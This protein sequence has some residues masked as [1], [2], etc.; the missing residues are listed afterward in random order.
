MMGQRSIR[1]AL[2]SVPS[3]LRRFALLLLLTLG[4]IWAVEWVAFRRGSFWHLRDVIS[5]MHPR[6][7]NLMAAGARHVDLASRPPD[8]PRLLVVGS[9][10]AGATFDPAAFDTAWSAEAS[11]SPL[12]ADL[13]WLGGSTLAD[14]IVLTQYVGAPPPAYAVLAFAR[15]DVMLSVTKEYALGVRAFH[16]PAMLPLDAGAA[17]PPWSGSQRLW[18]LAW[19]GYRHRVLAQQM[20][21]RYR[22]GMRGP[23]PEA[24]GLWGAGDVEDRVRFVVDQPSTAPRGGE[25]V[26]IP[27][28]VAWCRE[29]GTQPVLWAL[30]VRP[31]RLQRDLAADVGRT[32]LE[33]MAALAEA[34][35]A[36]LID[37]SGAGRVGDYSETDDVHPFPQAAV[38]VTRQFADALAERHTA[39]RHTP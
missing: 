33:R 23:D 6:W 12:G 39:E 18:R 34:H 29:R 36:W 15:R 30:P 37:L 25:L 7:H 4:M 31:D 8:R 2:D 1:P 11:R 14:H 13:V 24:A 38:R 3:T 9:S 32:Y 22:P 17:T 35:D 20:A 5:H 26:L 10:I 19:P 16:T 21:V 28:W 27:P